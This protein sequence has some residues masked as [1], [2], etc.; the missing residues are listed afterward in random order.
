MIRF[1]KKDESAVTIP[2]G[3][4]STA[5]YSTGI[6]WISVQL[7]GPNYASSS[8][9]GPC[10]IG[11]LNGDGKGDLLCY[12]GIG[13]NWYPYLANGPFPDLMAQI[14]NSLDGVISLTHKPL[15]DS[16]VYT[17]DTNAVYPRVDLK[18]PLYV[19]SAHSASNGLGANT[20]QMSYSYTGAKLEFNGRGFLGFRQMQTTDPQTFKTLITFSQNWPYTGMPSQVKR[21]KADGSVL[22]QTDS[23]FN[24]IDFNS[25]CTVAA[26]ARYFPYVSQSDQVNYDLNGAFVSRTSTSNVFDTYGNATSLV[27]TD[28]TQAGGA[29]GYAKTT[30][31]T[32]T[33]DTTNWFLGRL[34]RSTVLSTKP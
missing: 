26:G 33:N 14:T 19:T 31:N 28:K 16:T 12:S 32:Y 17:K 24:C 13:S 9:I 30:T 1:N 2:W 20:N 7:S 34:T 6:D 4:V 5:Y 29:T 25:G 27:V 15:T 18:G 22:S 8:A 23:I 10:R 3:D 21:L 11:D